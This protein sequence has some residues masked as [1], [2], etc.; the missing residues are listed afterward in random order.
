MSQF[1]S[2]KPGANITLIADNGE[3]VQGQFIS[4]LADDW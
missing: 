3:R 4:A 2:P 1:N